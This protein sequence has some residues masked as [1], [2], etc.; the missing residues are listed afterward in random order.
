MQ[1]NVKSQQSNLHMNL[2]A[3]CVEQFLLELCFG[4]VGQACPC[5]LPLQ[6]ELL[7]MDW[8]RDHV[9]FQVYCVNSQGRDRRLGSWRVSG[10]GSGRR[11]GQGGVRSRVWSGVRFRFFAINLRVL[12]RKGSPPF[13]FLS[14]P[15]VSRVLSF[16]M[17]GIQPFSSRSW[18]P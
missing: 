14:M 7:V 15:Q 1:Q 2:C 18:S 11:S 6:Q 5:Q 16:S 10:R 3:G 8:V 17:K 4:S 13:S 12:A 9:S